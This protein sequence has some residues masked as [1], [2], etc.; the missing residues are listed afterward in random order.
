MTSRHVHLHSPYARALQTQANVKTA[1]QGD[2]LPCP[3]CTSHRRLFPDVD[4]L[5]THVTLEHASILQNMTP[6]RSREYLRDEALRIKLATERSSEATA[7]G[8]STLDIGTLSLLDAARA[9]M[10]SSARKRPADTEFQA[11][12]GKIQ[13]PT[14]IYDPD[15]HHPDDLAALVSVTATTNQKSAER[16]RFSPRHSSRGTNSPYRS[17]P[18]PKIQSQHPSSYAPPTHTSI[19]KTQNTPSPSQQLSDVRKYDPRYP[20]LLLQPD[21]RPISQEQLAAEVKSIYAGLT[22]VETKCIHVD[23]TQAADKDGEISQDHWQALIALHRT[24][25]HEHHDFFLASQHPSAS[26]ALRRLA[27]KY[28]MPARMWRHGIYSFLELLRHRLPESMDYMLAFIYLAYQMTALLYE[29]VPAFGDTWIECLGD[30]GRYRMAV[31]EDPRDREI[32]AGVARSWYSKTSDRIPNVG[33]LYHHLAILARPVVLPQLY[34]YARSLT[35]L[36]PFASAR[37]SI[38]KL[39]DPVLAIAAS[40]QQVLHI[41]TNFIRTHAILF[42]RLKPEDFEHARVTFLGQLDS[43][44]GR[45]TAKWRE[46]GVHIAVTNIAG[47]FDY[48][49]HDSILRQIFLIHLRKVLQSRSQS[50]SS[51][52]SDESEENSHISAEQAS[53]KPSLPESEISSKLDTLSSDFTFSGAYLLLTSTFSAVL[54]R[55]DDKNVL[56]FVHVMLAFFSSIAAIPQAAHLADH[57]PWSEIA[58]FL[59][60]LVKSERA[61]QLVAG[62]LFPPLQSDNL[63][64]PD[65]YLIRGQL[66]CQWYFPDD[67]FSRKHDEEDRYLEPPSTVKA[68]AERVLRLGYHIATLHRWISYDLRSHTFTVFTADDS[69]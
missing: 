13:G 61:E 59:N 23:R 31:E 25:L 28:Q 8:G 37:E 3:Y 20:D 44:I 50:R 22:M 36:Q 16:L 57:A 63:P 12:R 14:L 41:D 35:C 4:Q 54:R 33:R 19:D 66:W 60:A 67:W 43:E 15:H 26:P 29:T 2:P 68:R 24:L 58:S 5:F 38:L 39:L 42:K 32:W 45:V 40:G 34:Y 48:G 64:L 18:E 53:M 7:G 65:D 6:S 56:P 62:P 21:S 46:K 10:P 55:V 11:R 27:E 9:S 69:S 30:L 1:E 47:L 49:I 17:T 51:T 52:P